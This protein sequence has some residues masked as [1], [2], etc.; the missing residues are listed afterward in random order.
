MKRPHNT[1][2]V[3]KKAKVV[4]HSSLKAESVRHHRRDTASVKEQG[5]SDGLVRIYKREEEDIERFAAFA[6]TL[7]R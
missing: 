2:T 6:K 1:L 5:Y 3:V 4:K 7:A